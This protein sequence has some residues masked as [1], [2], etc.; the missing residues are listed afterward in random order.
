MRETGLEI[1]P[2]EAME[3]LM[4]NAQSALEHPGHMESQ[5]PLL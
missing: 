5:V 4:S 3:K 2:E 1:L